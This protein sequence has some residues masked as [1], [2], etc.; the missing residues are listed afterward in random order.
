MT[1]ECTRIARVNG[2][3]DDRISI[4]IGSNEFGLKEEFGIGGGDYIHFDYCLDC[5]KIQAKFPRPQISNEICAEC[6]G[7]EFGEM[8]GQ[9]T[10]YCKTCGMVS[11]YCTH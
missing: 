5:G 6:G 3:V 4:E 10:R 11:Q 9:Y 7:I 2:K 8:V 1:C